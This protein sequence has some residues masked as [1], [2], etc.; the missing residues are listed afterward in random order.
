MAVLSKAG[1]RWK[2][3]EQILM[4]YFALTDRDAP[5]I[6][7]IPAII[8]LFYLVSP[9]DF[10]PDTIPFAGWIDDLIIVPLLLGLS[11]KLLPYGI[12]QNAR[13][14][15]RRNSSRINLFLFILGIVFILI[16]ILFIIFIKKLISGA[17]S[18]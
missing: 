5:W 1:R 10:I 12:R 7:R 13:A 9:I 15:A 18:V 4:L 2:W 14:Q 16:L 17:G 8:S 11:A 3:K 6:A